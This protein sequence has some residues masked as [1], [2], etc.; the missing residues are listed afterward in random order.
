LL[1]QEIA[2][3][4]IIE[5]NKYPECESKP[6]RNYCIDEITV[7]IMITGCLIAKL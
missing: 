6:A 7:L 2:D 1:N 4:I 3:Q 5:P